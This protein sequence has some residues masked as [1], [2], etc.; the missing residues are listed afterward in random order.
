MD[1][2][3]ISV[4][5]K[6]YSATIYITKTFENSKQINI[7]FAQRFY[8]FYKIFSEI[9]FMKIENIQLF[10]EKYKHFE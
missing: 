10:C 2:A 3:R 9:K 7:K 6:G 8:K 1:V 4:W 5:G